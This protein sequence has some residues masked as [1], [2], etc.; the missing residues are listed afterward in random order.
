MVGA[1]MAKPNNVPLL[2][3]PTIPGTFCRMLWDAMSRFEV[4]GVRLC[5]SQKSTSVLFWLWDFNVQ[6]FSIS[7]HCYWAFIQKQSKTTWAKF[8]S[9][10]CVWYILYNKCVSLLHACMFVCIFLVVA[11]FTNAMGDTASLFTLPASKGGLEKIWRTNAIRS[12]NRT[13]AESPPGWVASR[14]STKKTLNFGGSQIEIIQDA[15]FSGSF[16]IQKEWNPRNKR[17]I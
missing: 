7:S 8:A 16:R 13:P 5:E 12:F 14:I 17:F 2:I 6:L 15:H 1:S 3:G 11:Q 9:Q 4:F 10:C